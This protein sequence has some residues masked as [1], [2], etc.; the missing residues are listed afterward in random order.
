MIDRRSGTEREETE[1]PDVASQTLASLVDAHVGERIR[2]RR[3]EVGYTQQA[4]AKAVK[5]SYQQVQK[6]E[7]GSNRV[8]A[9]KLYLLA[10]ALRVDVGYFYEHFGGPAPASSTVSRDSLQLARDAS[11]LPDEDLRRSIGKLVR[12]VNVWKGTD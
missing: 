11:R 12:A 9:G 3:L 7:A 6:Y 1:T 2:E 5:I 8:S 10:S 4:L